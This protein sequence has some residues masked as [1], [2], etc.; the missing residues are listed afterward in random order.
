MRTLAEIKQILKEEEP[1]L[2]EKYGID[3]IGVFGSYVRDEKRDD[4]DLDNIN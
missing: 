4:S 1:A 3:V 2:A